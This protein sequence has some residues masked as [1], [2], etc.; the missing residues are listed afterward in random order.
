MTGRKDYAFDLYHRGI[1]KVVDMPK[2]IKLSERQKRQVEVARTGKPFW[3]E[4]A[5]KNYLK[6]LVYPLSFLDFEAFTT[7][8]PA[9]H[10]MQPYHYY[11]CQFSLHIL[12]KPEGKLRHFEFLAE[13]NADPRPAFSQAL[14]ERIPDKGS[15]ITYSPY[16]KNMLLHTAEFLPSYRAPFNQIIKRMSDLAVIFQKRDVVFPGFNGSASIKAVLPVL[17]PT[18]SY[19]NLEIGEGG[20]ACDAFVRLMDPDMPKKEREKIRKALLTYCGQDTMAMVKLL[21]VLKKEIA[22]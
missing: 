19:D 7:V 4:K 3:N 8:V 12:D 10:G 15:V 20:A 13:A 11:P 9:Y 16:E 6:T 1:V 17:V 21:E 14:A 2:E 18:M 5:V 22:I